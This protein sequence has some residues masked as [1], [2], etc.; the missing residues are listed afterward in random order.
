MK[1]AVFTDIHGNLEALESIIEDIKNQNVDKIICLGD[2]IGLGPNS[3]ECI[4]LLIE[5]NIEMTYGNHELYCLKGTNID[6]KIKDKEEQNHHKWIKEC[7]TKKELDFISLCSPYY[8]CKIE[9]NNKIPNRK[10][11]FSHYLIN[12]RKQDYPFEKEHLKN[13]IKLWIKYFDY[14]KEYIIGHLHKSF[15][16]NE[17]EGINYDYVEE[18]D[19]LPNI[20]VL[21]S[22]GCTTNDETSYMIITINK[23]INYKTI[24]LKYDRETFENKIKKIDF[25]DKKNILKFFFGIED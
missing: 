1:I 3:K 22:S 18:I 19:E 2:T 20:S 10:I 9:Y 16:E 12:D 14:N 23:S 21:D 25:P 6:K 15:D 24:K 7:L 17:V 11:I 5:N 13:D 8:E 4:D